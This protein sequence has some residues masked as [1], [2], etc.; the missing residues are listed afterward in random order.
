MVARWAAGVA[1]VVALQLTTHE[2]GKR[3]WHRHCWYGTALACLRR[4]WCCLHQPVHGRKG[5]GHRMLCAMGQ[6]R[7]VLVVGVSWVFPAIPGV[8]RRTEVCWGR[9]SRVLSVVLRDT[10]GLGCWREL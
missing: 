10:P 5:R 2:L 9:L 8:R 6:L 1:P 4:D 3:W 7:V